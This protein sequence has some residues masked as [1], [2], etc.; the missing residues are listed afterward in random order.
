MGDDEA[1]A[2]IAYLRAIPA[3]SHAIPASVCPPIK[4]NTPTP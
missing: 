1:R 2:I 4:P 3:V